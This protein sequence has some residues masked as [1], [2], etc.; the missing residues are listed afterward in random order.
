MGSH[1]EL[2]KCKQSESVLDERNWLEWVCCVGGAAGMKILMGGCRLFF[3][4]GEVIT[5]AIFV[6]DARL[7]V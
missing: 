4:R 2:P 6:C 1:T 7:D 5:R 3:S